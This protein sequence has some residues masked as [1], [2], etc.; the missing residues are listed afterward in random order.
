M[1]V[2]CI[3]GIL[4]VALLALAG[5]AQAQKAADAI[6]A[7]DQ[8]WEKAVVAR[9]LEK[10]V[11]FCAPEA[12]MLPPNAPIASGTDAI[13]KVLAGYFALPGFNL[14]WASV[15]AEVSRSGDMG[16]TRGT[17]QLSFNGPSGQKVSDT[18]KY[19]T[20]WKKQADGSWKVVA[21]IFNS[22]LPAQ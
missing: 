5:I 2:K 13:R 14:T 10:S 16:Y 9:D 18:G 17:F 19:V 6:R 21:D 12:S 11:A 3:R 22:D 7:A 8:Q 15:A 1:R 20:V 4:V